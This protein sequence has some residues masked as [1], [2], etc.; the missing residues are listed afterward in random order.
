MMSETVLPEELADWSRSLW[1]KL[2]GAGLVF[3]VLV[4]PMAYALTR[5]LSERVV[6][7][8]LVALVGPVLL[9]SAVPWAFLRRRQWREYGLV[10]ER[11]RPSL[12]QFFARRGV[13]PEKISALIDGVF[14]RACQDGS[15]RGGEG[16]GPW[17][18][19]LA[20][21]VYCD[22][23]ILETAARAA[24]GAASEVDKD[25]TEADGALGV[26]AI[27]SAAEDGERLLH[28]LEEALQRLPEPM[29]TFMR[30]RYERGFSEH[31]VAVLTRSAAGRA[32]EL[33]RRGVA[34]LAQELPNS[35]RELEQHGRNG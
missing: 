35:F 17:L 29:R 11:H 23:L 28:R 19:E 10:V 9:G 31:E 2:M 5:G 16:L 6:L 34:I 7:P 21:H 14:Q 3:I 33:L 27:F 4:L 1:G 12:E 8:L 26:S 32:Q 13:E 20:A 15:R 25:L 24:G 22:Q 18:L 30:L